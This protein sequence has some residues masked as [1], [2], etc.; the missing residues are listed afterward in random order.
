MYNEDV[1]LVN[2]IYA[3]KLFSSMVYIMIGILLVVGILSSV[4]VFYLPGGSPWPVLL[5]NCGIL[6]VTALVA[7]YF[8]YEKIWIKDM[9]MLVM[10]LVFSMLDVFF[11]YHAVILMVVPMVT[12]IRYFNKRFTQ[13]VVVVCFVVFFISSLLGAKYGVMDLNNLRMPAGTVADFGDNEY[14]AEV[15]SK[16][17]YDHTR[18]ALNAIRQSYAV[19]AMLSVLVAAGSIRIADQ[20]RKLIL[21]QQELSE[22]SARVGAELSVATKIQED[23]LPSC[24]PAFPKRME[25]DLFASM[26]PAKEV[27][28]DF[29]DFFLIDDDH[30]GLVIADVSGKGIPAAMFMMASKNIIANNAMVG[31]SPKEIL[32]K[33]N[34][35]I[36]ENNSEDMF[37]TVWIGILTISTGVLVCSSAGHEYPI[38]KHDNGEFERVI[39]E[40]G[41]PVGFLEEAE[42]EEY[43][44]K[45]VPGD[46]LFVYTDGLA[47]ATNIEENMYGTGRILDV[48]NQKP[49]STCEQMLTHIWTD[50]AEFVNGAEQFDDL[51]M[52]ALEYRG[53]VE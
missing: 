24:F 6:L 2:E 19:R 53:L 38:L 7:K 45:L 37:V 30:L 28:G 41:M 4:G 39:D 43:E 17:D 51:T 50:V 29:Y 34:D 13:G 52:L 21:R 46:K 42:Y 33:A 5:T 40:H 15:L 12:S 32:K 16:L 8:N 26:T 20:G 14:P 9:L 11:T 1:L 44:L 18:Y 49:E 27:G 47:E 36:C 31:F 3:N 35:T 23:M 48:L 10:I 22:T 25:F